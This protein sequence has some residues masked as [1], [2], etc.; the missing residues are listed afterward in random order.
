[1]KAPHNRHATSLC[2]LS[3]HVLRLFSS[4]FS[5]EAG[6]ATAPV[7]IAAAEFPRLQTLIDRKF[8]EPGDVDEALALV[9]LLMEDGSNPTMLRMGG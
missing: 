5:L 8:V 9:S 4:S 7:L 3:C 2:L 6:L 1:M